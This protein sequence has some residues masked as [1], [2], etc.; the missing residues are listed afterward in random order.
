MPCG[1]LCTAAGSPAC[2]TGS[3]G[4]Q[5]EWADVASEHHEPLGWPP[6]L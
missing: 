4:W 3:C 1:Y 6:D 5:K 2:Q